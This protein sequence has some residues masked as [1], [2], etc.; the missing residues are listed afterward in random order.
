MIAPNA[1]ELRMSEREW[2]SRVLEAARLYGWRIAHFRPAP[3]P[4]RGGAWRTPMEGDP[5]FPDLVLAKRGLVI[6]AELKTETGRLTTGQ[7]AWLAELPPAAMCARTHVWR[8]SDWPEVV[9]I[10]SAPGTSTA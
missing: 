8:P 3:D 1:L 2:Q 7:A 9:R 4:R 6:F 10:L 5:G